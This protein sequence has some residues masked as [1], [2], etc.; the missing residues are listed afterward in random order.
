M[1]VYNPVPTKSDVSLHL[2]FPPK[3]LRDLALRA[4]ENGTT[5]N[6]EISIRLA[7]SLER[8][9]AM[10]EKDNHLAYAAF[11]KIQSYFGGK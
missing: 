4:E 7:R 2:Q 8:D 5:L 11:Q 9:L 1:T 6:F 3:I 10:I